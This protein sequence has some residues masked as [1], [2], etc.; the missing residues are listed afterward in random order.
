M[1]KTIDHINMY[2]KGPTDNNISFKDSLKEIYN[3]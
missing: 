2:L 1:F 3:E